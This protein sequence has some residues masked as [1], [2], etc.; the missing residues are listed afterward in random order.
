MLT[1]RQN[2]ILKY[3]VD[4]YSETGDPVGSKVLAKKL[5]ISVS[6]ATIRNEMVVLSNLHLIDQVHTSSGRIPSNQG[7]RYYVDNLAK[8]LPLDSKYRDYISNSLSGSFRQIDDIVRQ[9]AK[10]LSQVTDYAAMTFSPENSSNDIINH[11]QLV[12]LNDHHLMA[13]IVM[14]NEQVE[15]QS[16]LVKQTVTVNQIE[17]TTNFLNQHLSGLTT[18][19]TMIRIQSGFFDN[20]KRYIK[21]TTSILNAFRYLIQKVVSDRYFVSGR[22]NLFNQKHD[23]EN[24]KPL[25]SFL[26]E[27]SRLT[28]IL[29]HSSQPIS[30]QIGPELQDDVLKDY[31]LIAGTYDVG[32]H[33]IGRIA[34]IGPTRMEYPKVLGLVDAFRVEM[35]EQIKNYYHSYDQ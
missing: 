1:E 19:Q 14:E 13:V 6:S 24:A 2:L 33:G 18:S 11:F 3:I 25:Y 34:V 28:E 29:N 31:S 10:I 23:L 26:N 22:L 21:D 17:M 15:S 16:F 9:S 32:I 8:P 35:Q 5:P 20:L 30:V 12:R 7:Y 4:D 27:N